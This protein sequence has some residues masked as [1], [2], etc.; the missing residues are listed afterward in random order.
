MLLFAN[1]TELTA[2]RFRKRICRR[3][4]ISFALSMKPGSDVVTHALFSIVAAVLLGL[5]GC[6]SQSTP[7]S[8]QGKALSGYVRLTQKQVGFPGSYIATDDTMGQERFPAIEELGQKP[9][10]GSVRLAILSRRL[11]FQPHFAY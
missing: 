6:A 3:L 9:H 10:E 5:V 8:V 7:L 4:I 1:A 11:D 2:F